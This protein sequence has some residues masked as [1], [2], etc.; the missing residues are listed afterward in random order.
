MLNA[1]PT[2]TRAFD[3]ISVQ[4]GRCS[5]STDRNRSSGRSPRSTKL[6]YIDTVTVRGSWMACLGGVRT[7]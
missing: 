7:M 2:A 3:R 5:V 4:S 1:A 6:A